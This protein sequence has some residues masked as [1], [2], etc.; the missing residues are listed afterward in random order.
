MPAGSPAVIANGAGEG[1]AFT[2]YFFF[3]RYSTKARS[4][5]WQPVLILLVGLERA[6]GQARLLALL[7][8][9]DIGIL[10]SSTDQMPAELRL[11][12]LL[13]RVAACSSS[14]QIR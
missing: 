12:C 9:A 5:N 11:P 8:F 7:L 1:V 14:L 4:R 2:S 6:D 3:R 10:R 13:C